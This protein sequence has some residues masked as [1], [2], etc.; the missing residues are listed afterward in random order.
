MFAKQHQYSK[1]KQKVQR[2]LPS[3]N[4]CC[5]FTFNMKRSPSRYTK[6]PKRDRIFK[7]KQ[8]SFSAQCSSCLQQ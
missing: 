2:K 8:K 3:T 4:Y 5:Y 1:E 7:K 6:I